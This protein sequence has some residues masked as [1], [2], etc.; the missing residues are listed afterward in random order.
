VPGNFF[1]K[2]PIDADA[3]ILR[4]IV[5]DWNDEDALAILRQMDGYHDDDQRWRSGAD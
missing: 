4:N 2:I 5:H 3:Y 1:E